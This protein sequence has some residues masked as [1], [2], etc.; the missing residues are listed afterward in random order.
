MEEQY[1]FV[2]TKRVLQNNRVYE[3]LL[4]VESERRGQR[5]YQRVVANLGRADQLDRG[6]IDEMI[7]AL[8]KYAQSVG[9]VDP[10]SDTS[11]CARS[12]CCRSGSGCGNSSLHADT[13]KTSACPTRRVGSR[14]CFILPPYPCMVVPETAPLEPHRFAAQLSNTRHPLPPRPCVSSLPA[15]QPCG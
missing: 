1:L 6:R 11:G 3:Y 8:G 14:R 7:T 15:R 12:G 10:Y 9:P 5:M 4:L 13:H 2:R